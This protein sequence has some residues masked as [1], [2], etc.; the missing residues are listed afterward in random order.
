MPTINHVITNNGTSITINEDKGIDERYYEYVK[1]GVTIRIVHKG[2]EIDDQQLAYLINAY[3]INKDN[4]GVQIGKSENLQLPV[5]G[6]TYNLFYG[7][8]ENIPAMQ[9]IHRRALN[10]LLEMVFGSRFYAFNPDDNLNPIQP[11]V[12]TVFEQTAPTIGMSD[13]VIG[14][15][16]TDGSGTYDYSVDGGNTWGNAAT[17]LTGLPDGTYDVWVRDNGVTNAWYRSE[18]VVLTEV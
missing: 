16:H 6:D 11:V 15:T 10:G 18:T 17:I 1:D 13:G 5:N 12:F 7:I 3:R 2:E 9:A 8:T 14:V 4:T